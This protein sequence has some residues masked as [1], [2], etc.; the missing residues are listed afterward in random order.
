MVISILGCGWYGKALA[1]ALLQKGIVVNGSATST[2]KLDALKEID[3]KPY[4][5]QVGVE[6]VTFDSDFFK[7]DILIIS[8]PPRLKKGETTAYLPK[9]KHIIQ[10][11]LKNDIQKVIYISSTGVYGDH[12]STVN[13]LNDPNPDTESRRVLLEAENLFKQEITSRT[14]I[15]R[16]G[17]LV[18]PGRHPG[19]FFSGKKD[20]P[21]GLAPVNLIHLN[22]CIGISTTIIEQD[23]FGYLFNAC[24]P[25]HP[26]KEDFYKEASLKGG[27]EPPEFIHELKSWKIVDSIHLKPI[28]NYEFKVQKWADCSFD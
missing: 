21:N 18:G 27:Y 11:I 25:D 15:I 13:E 17:G 16:F 20:I 26:P 14:N 19:Q 22:D 28:L 10:T 1:K 9:I 8:L 23:A 6:G 7:C 3:V 5:V 12:N 2:E 24:S 4:L